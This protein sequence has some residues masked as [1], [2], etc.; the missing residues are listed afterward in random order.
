MNNNNSKVQ[1]KMKLMNQIYK[2]IS[3][4]TKPKMKMR[5]KSQIGK[6]VVKANRLKKWLEVFIPNLLRIKIKVILK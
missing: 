5:L 3:H 6:I 2:K 1:F 4:K